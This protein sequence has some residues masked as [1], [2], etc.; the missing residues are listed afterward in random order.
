MRIMLLTLCLFKIS[1]AFSQAKIEVMN[2]PK[3]LGVNVLTG[4]P[5]MGIAYA[6]PERI[7][8][9]FYDTTTGYIT[10]QQRETSRNGKHWEPKGDIVQFDVKRDSVLWSMKMNYMLNE[11]K[12]L[13]G[14]LLYGSNKMG[15][16]L[17]LP[18]GR[19]KWEVRNNLHIADNRV[20]IGVGYRF[21][22]LNANSKL[23]E[24]IELKS[25]RIVWTREV[26]RD[27]GW[28]EVFPLKD[29]TYLIR[30]SG[31]VQ[32]DPRTGKGWQYDALTGS[33]NYTGLVAGSAAAVATGLLF[34]AYVM[35]TG[36]NTV[37]EL[38]SGPL[39]EDSAIY[40][41][42]RN[43]L[44]RLSRYT[45]EVEWKYAIPKDMG[46]KSVLFKK[47][48]LLYML[49]TGSGRM[50]GELVPFGLPFFA[51][52]EPETGKQVFFSTINILKNGI[53]DY[54]LKQDNILLIFGDRILKYS[55]LSGAQE[56]EKMLGTKSYGKA[57]SEVGRHVY[58]RQAGTNPVNLLESDSTK[59]FLYT[60]E[61]SVLSF[62]NHLKTVGTVPKNELVFQ[63]LHH[64]GLDFILDSSI[65]IVLNEDGQRVAELDI[66]FGAKMYG[67][68]VYYPDGRVLKI[69]D[70]TPLLTP[71][72]EDMD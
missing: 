25:G 60:A 58:L 31:I 34:G 44:V 68:S 53:V 19:S 29:T 54:S 59:L 64:K 16:S 12:Q 3:Q 13:N 20:G 48:G 36:P 43:E 62:D 24:G 40:Y 39:V 46:S 6:F 22:G 8:K 30:S 72:L 66:G 21:N 9:T 63:F 33:K 17:D 55:L 51:A 52:F 70:I 23:L 4:K 71:K 67:N 65:A 2:S 18:T 49:N 35:P 38:D 5:M 50:Y 10:V 56:A 42:S 26:D 45:G 15:Y 27:Y 41:A 37:T 32:L 28:T 14:I 11:L 69:L 57:V 47:N 7:Q 61:D 1:L